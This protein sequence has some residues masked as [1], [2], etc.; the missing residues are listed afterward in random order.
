MVTFTKF[1]ELQPLEEFSTPPSSPTASSSDGPI[2]SNT[3]GSS[4]F[5]WIKTPYQRTSSS[6]DSCSGT[7]T[8][9]NSDDPFVI[10]SDYAWITAE[11]KR[12][13]MEEKNKAKKGKHKDQSSRAP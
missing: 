11:V 3:S 12:R 5:R 4:W 6:S 8:E 9:N 2:V 7:K 10:P 1:E 13:R